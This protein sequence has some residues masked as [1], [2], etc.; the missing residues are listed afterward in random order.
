[1]RTHNLIPAKTSQVL[2]RP[3][4]PHHCS[5]PQPA[6]CCPIL[7]A[8]PSRGS[9]LQRRLVGPWPTWLQGG[10]CSGQLWLQFLLWPG[11]HLYPLWEL[12]PPHGPASG[13]LALDS[14]VRCPVPKVP[15]W[16]SLL[17]AGSPPGSLGS[18]LSGPEPHLGPGPCCR[19]R[20]LSIADSPHHPACGTEYVF[21]QMEFLPEPPVGHAGSNRSCRSVSHHNV[22]Q[23]WE[24]SSSY[25][26]HQFSNQDT[27][28]K[29]H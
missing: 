11:H 24:G 6:P 13:A 25:K 8:P 3:S 18:P 15:S 4:S 1:M 23:G 29:S 27:N 14:S 21:L 10:H 20:P 19:P 2:L 9:R 16:T 22:L 17:S 5:Q 7:P 26:M 28:A 12:G